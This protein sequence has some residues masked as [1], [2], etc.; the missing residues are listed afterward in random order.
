MNL[1]EEEVFRFYVYN[2]YNYYYYFFFFHLNFWKAHN[3][4]V[5]YSGAYIT[6]FRTKSLENS[7][8]FFSLR[9]WILK[10]A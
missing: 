10:P 6:L 1:K 2:K 9:H 3:Q 5:N 8:F 7:A 4:R